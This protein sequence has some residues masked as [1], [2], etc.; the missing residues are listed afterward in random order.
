MVSGLKDSSTGIQTIQKTTAFREAGKWEKKK[1][2][3]EYYYKKLHLSF[4][5]LLS[6]VFTLGFFVFVFCGFLPIFKS[7][8]YRLLGI[9]V[10]TGLGQEPLK[11]P[12]FFCFWYFISDLL[13]NPP[14]SL[15]Y[16]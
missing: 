4:S 1:K 13:P 9:E 2:V 7:H 5:D 8:L 12:V 6:R 10:V 11:V 14:T 16:S 3:T 15:I